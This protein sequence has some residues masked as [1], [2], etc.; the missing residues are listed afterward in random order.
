MAETILQ[1][2]CSKCHRTLS[3]ENF[4]IKIKSKGT[5]Q[6]HC[7][8]CK[9]DYNRAHYSKN[10]LN[11]IERN[12]RQRKIIGQ[13]VRELKNAPCTDCGNTFPYY[14]MEYDH[15]SPQNKTCEIGRMARSDFKA[16]KAEIAKCDLVC[17]NCHKAR[18]H[19]RRLATKSAA[20]TVQ[21]HTDCTGAL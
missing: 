2:N 3:I 1:K 17:A 18:T 19:L 7:R 13:K 10:K 21:L 20:A 6:S 4:Q 16:I 8:D 5:R 11:Y 15:L 14:V 12:R 9:N